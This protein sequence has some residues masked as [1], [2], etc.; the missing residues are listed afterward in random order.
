MPAVPRQASSSG[1]LVHGIPEKGLSLGSRHHGAGRIR[2]EFADE[3]RKNGQS[4]LQPSVSQATYRF[5]AGGFNGRMTG[6]RRDKSDAMPES[7]PQIGHSR[8]AP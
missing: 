4:A 5:L 1:W 6:L 7:P 3:W 8:W 2:F